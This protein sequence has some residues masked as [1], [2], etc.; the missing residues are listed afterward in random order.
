MLGLFVDVR[1]PM[2]SMMPAQTPSLVPSSP[3]PESRSR[4]KFEPSSW[5]VLCVVGFDG[6]MNVNAFNDNRSLVA[7]IVLCAG[8][9]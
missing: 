7:T 6:Q 3:L 8:K 1:Q 4:W 2:L 5:R 9:G